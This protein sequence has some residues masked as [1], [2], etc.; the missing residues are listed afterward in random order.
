[1]TSPTPQSKSPIP[2]PGASGSLYV[3]KASGLVRDI[4][5]P[6]AI[7]IA[8]SATGVVV[9]FLNFNAILTSFSGGD[10][11]LPFLVG[12]AIWLVALFA[13]RYLVVAVPRGSGEYVYVSRIVSPAAGAMIGGA[14]AILF[15]Y[16]AAI[17]AHS[18][19]LYASFTLS[20]LGSAFNSSALSSAANSVTSNLAVV[21][22]GGGVMILVGFLA[23]LPLKRAAQVLLTLCLIQFASLAVLALLLADHSHSD[24]V[25]A[26][27][28]YSQHRAA[29]QALIALGKANGVV[30]GARFGAMFAA[31]GFGFLTFYGVLYSYYV[32]GE[33]RRATRTYTWASVVSLASLVIGWIGLWALLRH[34]AGLHFMQAQQNVAV[35]NPT[36]YAKVTNLDAAS[37]G[38]G[39]GLVLSGDPISKIVFALAFPAYGIS[40]ALVF[41]A[42]ATR[43]LFALAFDR[44][45]PVRVAHVS[46]RG[47]APTVAVAIAVVLGLGFSILQT[48]ATLTNILGLLSL[49]DALVTI[50]AG[51]AAA[52]LSR[53]RPDLVLKPGQTEVPRLLGMARSTWFGILLAALALGVTIVILAHPSV[54]GKFSVESTTTL[55]VVLLVGP[56]I[57]LVARAVRL[58]RG[59]IDL[60]TVMRELPPD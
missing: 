13:Y 52:L 54:Y 25:T 42:V 40:T 41:V 44:V 46:E 35:G 37:G 26:F 2:Q 30:Y 18:T 45:L 17:G 24:F 5:I 49:F 11:Y 7:G 57:Y 47:N 21:L 10:I 27:A 38:L 20:A 31:I 1:V 8:L 33:L 56:A 32:G 28:R 50:T 4:G 16:T 59:Q 39:Y 60:R 19:G 29:Y 36:A 6:T 34:T 55:V 53:R 15:I 48:Y 3:R 9:C 23:I 14:I 22:I 58:R 43:V 51:V 12:A